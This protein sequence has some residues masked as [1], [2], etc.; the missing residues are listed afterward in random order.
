V[1]I[2]AAVAPERRGPT[3]G[4]RRRR[5]ILDAVEELLRDRSIAELSVEDVASAAG[6][7]RSGFYFYFDSKYAALGAL[8]AGVWDEMA[9]AAAPF[10]EGSE[11]PPAHYVRSVLR[12]VGVAWRTHEHLLVAMV[13]AAVTDPGARAL[14]EAWIGRFS[15]LAA[16]RIEAERTAGRAPSGPPEA[17]ALARVLLAMNE[18]AFYGDSRRGARAA[19]GERTVEALAGA[20]LA[21]VWGERLDEES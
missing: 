13:D 12:D 14:W 19:E 16:E 4:D 3:R 5:A 2:E 20:W 21:A 9:R 15:D 10:L 18:R 11:Q 6:I 17:G 8:L 1:R 7:T